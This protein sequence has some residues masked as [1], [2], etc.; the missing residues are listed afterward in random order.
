[1]VSSSSLILH[2]VVSFLSIRKHDIG[3]KI[4]FI[5][6]KNYRLF[7]NIFDVVNKFNQFHFFTFF[8]FYFTPDRITTYSIGMQGFPKIYFLPVQGNIAFAVDSASDWY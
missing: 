2:S 7:V 6:L 4:F 8:E 3:I 5:L 1:M